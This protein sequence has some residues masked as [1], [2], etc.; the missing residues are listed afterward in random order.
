[1]RAE[2]ASGLAALRETLRGAYPRTFLILGND[3]HRSSEQAIQQGASD[4]LWAYVHMRRA[5]FAG[6]AVY[7]YA[8][9]PPTPFAG[10]DWERY[11]VSRYVDPGCVSPEEGWRSVP[12]DEADLRYGTIAGDLNRL[13]GGEDVARAIFLCHSPPY[14]CLD[15]A[16]LDGVRVDHAPVDVH[17]GS[18]AL[19]RFIETRQPLLTLH[20]H[21]HEAARLTGRWHERIGRTH[22]LSAA[23][24]GAELALVRFD[25]ADLERATRELA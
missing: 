5:A 1:V 7:G 24:D 13:A 3:D 19:R 15:R 9:V 25:P 2:L 10:K 8:C 16:A 14:R 6:F 12:V 20:G 17:V 4:G 21:V 23:H 18:L 11:D 22:C